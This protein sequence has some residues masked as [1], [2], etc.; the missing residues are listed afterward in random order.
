MDSPCKTWP[1]EYLDAIAEVTYSDSINFGTRRNLGETFDYRCSSYVRWQI[2]SSETQVTPKVFAEMYGRY[3]QQLEQDEAIV[4]ILKTLYPD[5]KFDDITWLNIATGIK[6]R[7]SQGSA[8][9][10]KLLADLN[11]AQ[12]QNRLLEAVAHMVDHLVAGVQLYENIQKLSQEA[13][14]S[15]YSELNQATGIPLDDLKACPDLNVD[16]N[17][18]SI[19]M[20]FESA[21]NFAAAFKAKADAVVQ[22]YLT[23]FNSVDGLNLPGNLSRVWKR[24]IFKRAL[25]NA[26]LD[27]IVATTNKLDLSNLKNL[28]GQ[29]RQSKQQNDAD[30]LSKVASDIFNEF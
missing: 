23:N 27:Q 5:K 18:A 13:Q 12:D 8:A 28:L 4:H 24:D 14:D 25:P 3:L 16:F 19:V 29:Y 21:E 10:Q 17:N 26:R 15:I 1:K 9:E 22:K 30:G 2:K 20:G 7:L 6:E 11:N